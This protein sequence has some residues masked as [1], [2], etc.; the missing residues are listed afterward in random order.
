MKKRDLGRASFKFRT[1][2]L[3]AVLGIL[4]LS[5]Q[6]PVQAKSFS[7]KKSVMENWVVVVHQDNPLKELSLKQLRSYLLKEKLFWKKDFHV[8]PIVLESRDPRF[9]E[10]SD[11]FLNLPSSQY[12]RFWIEQKFKRGQTRPKEGDVKTIIK[13][14]GILKGALSVI[15][16]DSWEHIERPSVKSVDIRFDEK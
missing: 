11:T 12:P 4:I 15:P 7:Q 9:E 14:I 2:I 8:I 1:S 13:L 16:R 5:L 3:S 10:F 6:S